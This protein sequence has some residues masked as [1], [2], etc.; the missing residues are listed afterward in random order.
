MPVAAKQCLQ[1]SCS[2][3]AC[4]PYNTGGSALLGY[5]APTCDPGS[6]APTIDNTMP[7]GTHEWAGRR[8][9]ARSRDL[10]VQRGFA[11]E[12]FPRW[13]SNGPWPP[14]CLAAQDPCLG[15]V[16]DP[17]GGPLGVQAAL[18]ALVRALHLSCYCVSYAALQ[19]CLLGTSAGFDLRSPDSTTS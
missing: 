3:V 16:W 8:C 2:I 13:G 7:H 10:A 19:I 4:S 12:S 1:A 17:P 6:A 18:G 11:R 14:A 15:K 5:P 9:D